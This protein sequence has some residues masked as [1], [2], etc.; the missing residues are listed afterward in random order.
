MAKTTNKP[1]RDET[2]FVDHGGYLVRA[3]RPARGEPYEHRCTKE[4]FEAV[5]RAVAEAGGEFNLDGL[6]AA[7][8]LTWSQ[9]AVAFA[10]LKERSVVIPAGKR[11][12][13]AEGDLAFESAMIEYH[14]LR[15]NG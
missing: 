9:V 5:A 11:M 12:H 2:F 8:G 3:V 7:T 1:V 6:H 13:V 15:E 4:A 10:F 14:A